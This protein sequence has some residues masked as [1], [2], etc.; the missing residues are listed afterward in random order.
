MI[1]VLERHL[2]SA[3]PRFVP[4]CSTGYGSFE[5][6]SPALSVAT[7]HVQ[8]A[9]DPSATEQIKAPSSRQTR[10]ARHV[11]DRSMN[12]IARVFARAE[13]DAAL[14]YE[15]ETIGDVLV[16]GLIVE[17]DRWTHGQLGSLPEYTEARPLRPDE[18]ANAPMPAGFGYLLRFT[19]PRGVYDLP[20]RTARVDA[21]ETAL[22]APEGPFSLGDA[23]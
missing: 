17:I 19:I 2:A 1:H 7:F 20:P 21:V 10:P 6:R 16:D 14:E 12:G 13:V 15:N 5:R 22:A 18:I 11:R 23:S 4:G 8:L 9:R 3:L